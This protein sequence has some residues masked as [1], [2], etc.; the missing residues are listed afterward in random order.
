M[1][2]IHI[3]QGYFNTFQVVL[4]TNGTITLAAFLYQDIEWG[5]AQIGF[6]AGDGYSS[7]MLDE[8]LTHETVDELSNV[9]KPGVFMFRIDSKI[10]CHRIL[11]WFVC[12][13]NR[14]TSMRNSHCLNIPDSLL[15][16]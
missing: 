7:F 11:R 12:L 4:A 15:I 16:I 5:R 1:S 6:N 10:Q 14:T 3:I 13:G 2:N 9:E 8:V